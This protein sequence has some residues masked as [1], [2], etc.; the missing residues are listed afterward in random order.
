MNKH[1]LKAAAKMLSEYSDM[2][3]NRNCND[4]DMKDLGLPESEWEAFDKLCEQENHTPEDHD[5]D[6]RPEHYRFR[7]ADFMAAEAL[8]RLLARAAEEM[9]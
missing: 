7:Q 3:G 2:L 6:M 9:P 5:E 4:L 8:S 1:Y